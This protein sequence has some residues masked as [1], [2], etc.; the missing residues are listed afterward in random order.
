MCGGGKEV[1]RPLHNSQQK[2]CWTKLSSTRVRMHETLGHWQAGSKP[3]Q[4]EPILCQ[5]IP[6][7]RGFL[8][9]SNS[10]GHIFAKLISRT[11]FLC[12]DQT[13]PPPPNNS[14]SLQGCRTELLRPANASQNPSL[15]KSLQIQSK[16]SRIRGK[17]RFPTSFAP[18]TLK[19]EIAKLKQWPPVT[20]ILH[21]LAVSSGRK[22]SWHWHIVHVQYS[23][24]LV[25][26]SV[27]T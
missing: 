4:K 17:S 12:L 8:R 24:Y 5:H 19:I 10:G 14:I 13:P 11:L 27:D 16:G 21:V 1:G 9:T 6:P 23:I 2:C 3:A 15:N 26:R 22:P 20:W 25:L 18:K 7:C